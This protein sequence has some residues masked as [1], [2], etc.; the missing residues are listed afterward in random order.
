MSNIIYI[1]LLIGT[2]LG[3]LGGFC[4]KKSTTKESLIKSFLS[5]FLYLGGVLYVFSAILNIIV[6]K[7][8]PYS[9]VLPLTSITYVWSL[10]IS[11]YFLNEKITKIKI[12]GI[13]CIVIGAIFIGI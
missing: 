1:I 7:Q 13:I 12:Y 11:Y 5:P 6:L 10:F 4:L 8:L 3:A 2:L 9:V